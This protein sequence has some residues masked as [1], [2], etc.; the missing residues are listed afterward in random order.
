MLAYW[1]NRPAPVRYVGNTACY[2]CHADI[3][4]AYAHT[5][6]ART[7]SLAAPDTIHGNFTAGRNLMQTGNP[8]LHFRM[9]ADGG[10]YTQT[11]VF[12]TSS[13]ASV[14]RQ[15]VIDIIIGSGRKGQTYLHWEGDELCQL[16]VSYWTEQ[17]KWVNSP[18]FTDGTAKFDRP[19]T[20]RC[21][22]CHAS[23]VVPRG[24]PVNR[25]D[26]TSMVLGISCE[27]CHG[28]GAEHVRR[29]QSK[30]PPRSVVD[31]AIMNPARLPRERQIDLC[32]WCH[33][34]E[35]RALTP[36]L[37]FRPGDDLSKHIVFTRQPPNAPLDVHA[38]QIQLLERSRCFQESPAMTCATCH[39]VHRP[40]RDLTSMATNCRQCHQVE[41]CGKFAARGM[42]I[43]TSCVKCHM[44]LQQ[45]AQIVISDRNGGTLQPKVRNHHIAVY[46][47]EDD[48]S[49]GGAGRE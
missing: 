18:G 28:P 35:G 31:A 6:H 48:Q 44:P 30:T 26:S 13:G 1:I 7:S 42:T 27:K 41:D 4:A 3:A 2:T 39:N 46:P 40:Q 29:Y 36:P 14:E 34:G 12:R 45:T 5:A 20:A 22:E 38:S 21:L 10:R 43:A 25:F 16:P 47:E 49:G 23:T 24:P 15:E 32:A 8:D 19:I 11:A 9:N 33:A 17:H 37:S